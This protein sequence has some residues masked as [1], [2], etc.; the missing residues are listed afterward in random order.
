MKT[1]HPKIVLI[2]ILTVLLFNCNKSKSIKSVGNV[3]VSTSSEN[4][5]I[6]FLIDH[7]MGHPNDTQLSLDVLG[8]TD[9]VLEASDPRELAN[10]I[11]QGMFFAIDEVEQ[12]PHYL[13]GLARAAYFLD[14]GTKAV[15]WLKTA[16]EN[17]SA[18]A[19][20][21]LGYI[22]YY[23][24]ENLEK[25]IEHLNLAANGGFKDPQVDEVL[26]LCNYNPINEKFN[27]GDIITALFDK[28]WSYVD[29]NEEH[30][31]YLAKVHETLWN[32]DILWL[33]EDPEI[34]LELNPE[35]SKT[36]AA[37]IERFFGFFGLKSGADALQTAAIQDAKRLAI[38]YNTNPIAFRK[39]YNGI[40]E[41]AL[42]KK[43]N[44]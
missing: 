20:A 9:E 23:E 7:Y 15:E 37:W 29:S 11:E 28:N 38:L 34:L 44:Q 27:K 22:A 3:G 8:V 36:S 10:I 18:A 33:A 25:A 41:Y 13:F 1:L 4:T 21:Y 30:E 26:A 12:D 2:L 42:H 5:D 17:G 24:E 6:G 43:R 35:L 39:I 16:S 31:F 32:N 19:Q 40:S 14:Y